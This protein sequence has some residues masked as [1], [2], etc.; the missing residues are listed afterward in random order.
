ME[1]K[2]TCNCGQ[3]YIFNVEPD[4][5]QMPVP[6]HCPTCGAEG[7]Q[8]ANEILA[9]IVPVQPGE[10]AAAPPATPPVSTGFGGIRINLP[11]RKT[12]PP[13]APPPLTNTVPPPPPI[14]PATDAESETKNPGEPD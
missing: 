9:Q 4:N 2:I 3:K 7:T 6:V 13:N 14:T 10:S 12:A 5:G 1:I 8:I 11:P